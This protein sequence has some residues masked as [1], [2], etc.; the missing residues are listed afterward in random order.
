MAQLCSTLHVSALV[1]YNFAL[2]DFTMPYSTVLN[3]SMLR[4]DITLLHSASL[5]S[6]VAEPCFGKL[7]STKLGY[8]FA[9]LNYTTLGYSKLNCTELVSTLFGYNFAVLRC[10]NLSYTSLFFTLL[11]LKLFKYFDFVSAIALSVCSNSITQTGILHRQY[12]F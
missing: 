9:L 10:A 8:N 1:G 7:N 11:N 2:Q 6:T 3:R 12:D 5:C 4:L